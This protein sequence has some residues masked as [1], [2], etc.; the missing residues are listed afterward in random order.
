MPLPH[1]P[2]YR[3]PQQNQVDRCRVVFAGLIFAL[4]GALLVGLAHRAA[5][6]PGTE[7]QPMQRQPFLLLVLGAGF[8]G[9][10]SEGMR[11]LALVRKE[12]PQGQDPP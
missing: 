5:R 6:V 7:F 12:P 1:P 9:A 8:C 2:G 4:F 10:W 11:Q 3:P